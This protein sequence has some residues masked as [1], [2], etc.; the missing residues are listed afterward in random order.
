M[1][2]L[3]VFQSGAVPMSVLVAEIDPFIGETLAQGLNQQPCLNARL[4]AGSA[5]EGLD[6]A[7]ISY[8]AIL[9]I[10]EFL[11][12]QVPSEELSVRLSGRRI[13][14]TLV[15]GNRPDPSRTIHYLLLGCMGY[16]SRQDSLATMGRAVA[17]VAAGEY[18]APRALMPVLVRELRDRRGRDP[19]LTPREREILSLIHAGRTD[20]EIASLLFINRGTVRWHT[21]RLFSKIG[22]ENRLAAMEFAHRHDAA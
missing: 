1:S 18:W 9:L 5:R 2:A 3:A 13:V 12:R 15:L 21:R 11:L 6:A 14:P 10:S 7:E 17:V 22:V 16:L 8:P 19:V 20:R 4:V